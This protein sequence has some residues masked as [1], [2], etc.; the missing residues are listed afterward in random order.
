MT[1]TQIVTGL[2]LIAIIAV[3]I[4]TV[5]LN[6]AV[7]ACLV[8]AVALYFTSITKSNAGSRERS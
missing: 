1:R 5:G 7:I 2:I 6:P 4:A 8:V 3:V